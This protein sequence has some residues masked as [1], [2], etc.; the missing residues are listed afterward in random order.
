MRG[1][2]PTITFKIPLEKSMIAKA[3]ITFKQGD[4]V[5]LTK[6][7]SA[8]G[9]NDN[10]VQTTLTRDESVKFPDNQHIKVQLEIET[11]AGDVLKTKPFLVWSSELLDG[12]ALE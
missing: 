12:G 1:T 2:T 9:I 11:P 7:T 5:L 8:C 6:C 3:K 4:T 10:S